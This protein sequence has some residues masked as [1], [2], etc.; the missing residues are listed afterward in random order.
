[1]KRT[2][3]PF[4]LLM[5]LVVSAQEHPAVSA[6]A[7]TVYTGADGKFEAAPDTAVLSLNIAGQADTARAAYDAAAK[8][9]EQ[10]RQILRNN[11]IDPKEAQVGYYSTQP[12][13]DYKS[14]KRKVIGYRVTTSVTLKL[15]DFAK[16]GPITQQL[17]DSDVGESQS[18][19]YTLEKM[20]D[21]KSKA[22]EDAYHRARANADALAR[23]AGR[24]VG[25]LSY[26]SVDTFENIRP[27]PMP[28]VMGAMKM[29]AAA[30]PPTEEF[31]PQTVSVTAHVNALFQLK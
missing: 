22:V 24:S 4:I 21:A 3:L 1:M 31:T 12:M 7:N 19:T 13:F 17:A 26:A 29:E 16:I 25:E 10:A 28:R 14:S 30:A 5:V 15:K 2:L 23:V 11:G 9:A 20:D 27:I 18:L 6:Q 8:Q